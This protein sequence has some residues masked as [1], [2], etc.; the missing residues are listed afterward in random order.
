MRSDDGA[1][2]EPFRSVEPFAGDL[3]LRLATE[4]WLVLPPD[5]AERVIA[6]LVET[7][8][9]V[10]ACLR[11]A[12]LSLKLLGTADIA[13]DVGRLVV[14]CAFA[15]QIAADRWTQ[16]LV[17]LPKYIEAFRIAAAPR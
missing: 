5:Q 17:E 6:E 1:V 16:A 11:R 7:L 3:V 4:G 9:E 12:E 2:T 8:T 10:R 15:G 14:N 13:P